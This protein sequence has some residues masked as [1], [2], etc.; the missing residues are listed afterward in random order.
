MITKYFSLILQG[1]IT[2]ATTWIF[3]AAGSLALGISLG[4]LSC[5]QLNLSKIKFTIRMFSFIAKAIP[6]YVQILIA[7]FILPLLLNY[8]LSSWTSGILALII[9]SSGYVT[10]IIRAGINTIP[11]SQWDA[12]FVLGYSKYQTLMRIILPQV[13]NNIFPT[14]I[15]ELEQLL[16]STSLLATIGVTELTRTGINI[17]SRELNPVP[18][19]LLIATIY[20]LFSTILQIILIIQERYSYDYR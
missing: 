5:N 7:Y 19:Y 3:A 1:T 12:A 18:M 13:L 17:I 20:V 15:G 9:C 2:T 4:I 11:A 10:E 8:N 16:K 14:L 6:A